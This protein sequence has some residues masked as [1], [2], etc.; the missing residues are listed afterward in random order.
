MLHFEDI[1][2]LDVLSTQTSMDDLEASL[3]E[4]LNGSPVI[5][6]QEFLNETGGRK[7]SEDIDSLSPNSNFNPQPKPTHTA[8]EQEPTPV[9]TNQTFKVGEE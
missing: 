9:D 6:S 2:S 5:E 1:F 3:R 4:S 8:T 7:L